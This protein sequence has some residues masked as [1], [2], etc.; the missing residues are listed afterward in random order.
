MTKSKHQESV[1][2]A[3]IHSPRVNRRHFL[4]GA[5]TL[6][7]VS[8]T[9]TFGGAHSAQA[10]QPRHPQESAQS[11]PLPSWN[12]GAVKSAIVTFVSDVTTTGAPG[13]VKPAERIAVFDNDGTLWPE[14]P[15]YV[16]LAFAL[17]RVK[18]LAPQHPGWENEQPFKAALEGDTEALSVAGERGLLELITATH[19][20][21][22]TDEFEKIV[23]E[24]LAVARHPNFN[25]FY[26][27]LVYQPMLELLAYFRVNEFK[28]FITSGGGIEF[29]RPWAERTYGIPPEQVVGSSIKLKYEIRQ[30]K[31]VLVRLPD[32]NFIDDGPN[33]P[34]GIHMHIGRRPIAAIGNSDGDFQ[35]LEWTTSSPRAH[36]GLIV[37]HDDA[38]RE[39]AYDRESP[40]G[41]LDR[42]LEPAISR[43]WL[44]VSMRKDWKRVFSF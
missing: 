41:K 8:T 38:V 36:L 14:Q 30:G 3:E 13:F 20:G 6:A 35:M 2:Y 11:D 1:G 39:F 33:K 37:H 15:V 40:F 31:P 29:M 28:T 19:A 7:T 9:A 27:E 44:L 34:V 21:M 32:I 18:A 42:G 10:Q 24:W 16:Q 12:A 22:S 25:R 23:T 4:V 26:T 5:T 43:G 17:D